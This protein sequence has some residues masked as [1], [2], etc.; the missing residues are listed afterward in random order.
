MIEAGESSAFADD[1]AASCEAP[2]TLRVTARIRARWA[3]WKPALR[4]YQWPTE[5]WPG[6]GLACLSGGRA[7]IY[8]RRGERRAANDALDQPVRSI[9]LRRTNPARA[10][11]LRRSASVIEQFTAP[12]CET[13]FS[14]IIVPRG[15][16]SRTTAR[17]RRK[18]GPWSARMPWKWGRCR[19]RCARTPCDAGTSSGVA[20]SF[21]PFR[22]A[23]TW[24]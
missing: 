13:T 20:P 23:K 11:A 14:S 2:R 12:A 15:R 21:H 6:S 9:P 1:G 19:G 17:A 24:P 10:M 16:R 3:G 18:E 5:G 22:S 8:E 4:R 7:G